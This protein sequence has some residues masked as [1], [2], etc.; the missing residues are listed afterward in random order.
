[1][2]DEIPSPDPLRKLRAVS[3]VM[4]VAV[5]VGMAAVTVLVIAVF[6]IPAVTRVTVL[7]EILP[8]RLTEISA[9][10]RWLGLAV[11]AVPWQSCSMR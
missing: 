9:E 4:T 10:A 3:S 8:F 6:L 11:I 5:T 2:R 1:M 7:P